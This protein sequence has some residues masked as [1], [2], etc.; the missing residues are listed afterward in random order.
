M[1]WQITQNRI[2]P[3]RDVKNP[4]PTLLHQF[5]VLDAHPEVYCLGVGDD[6]GFGAQG[7]GRGSIRLLPPSS[8]RH[9]AGA[10]KHYE[11]RRAEYAPHVNYS[12]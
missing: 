6:R 10:G 5:R 8:S 12:T 7:L 3:G 9:R 11:Q 2:D 1:Q 4:G